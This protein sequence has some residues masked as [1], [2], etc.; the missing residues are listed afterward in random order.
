MLA[1]LTRETLI[2]PRRLLARVLGMDW[3][4]ALRWQ[5]FAAVVLVST[6]VS[7][8]FFM[9]I[10]R[11][12]M[13]APIIPGPFTLALANALLLLILVLAVFAVGRGFGGKASFGDTLVAI[14]LLQAIMLAVQV[15]QMALILVS[16]ALAD[17]F[18]LAS[19]ALL[20]WL[21]G[22]FIMQVHGF[23]SLLQVAFG[24]I[25]ALVG[26][27]L[28]FSLVMVLTGLSGQGI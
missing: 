28:L 26:L 16:T 23:R 12:G 1:E 20:L 10:D 25:G 19:L 2:H 7:W 14:S 6:L 8:L 15:V 9:V 22:N 27:S 17:L 4:A 5:V 24:I 11:D 21:L 18:G 3:S 13:L